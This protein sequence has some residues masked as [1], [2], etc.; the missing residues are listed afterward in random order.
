MS[1]YTTFSTCALNYITLFT[2]IHKYAMKTLSSGVFP[3]GCS[4]NQYSYS[5]VKGAKRNSRC[6]ADSKVA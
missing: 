5:Y 6:V 4:G 1:A 3:E 2:C